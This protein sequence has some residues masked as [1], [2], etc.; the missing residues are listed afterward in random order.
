MPLLRHRDGFRG[1]VDSED[2]ACLES[3][4]QE[5]RRSPGAAA[6][7]QDR[8]HLGAALVEAGAEELDASAREVLSTLAGHGQTLR[9]RVVVAPG[10]LVEDVLAHRRLKPRMLTKKL[11]STVW[12]PSAVRV[13]PGTTQRRVSW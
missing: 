5:R 3:L 6:V 1:G 2:V 13:A 10:V 4:A 11:E 8:P 9:E 12:T 7:V